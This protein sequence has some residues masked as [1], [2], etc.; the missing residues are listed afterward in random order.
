M[1]K[2]AIKLTFRMKFRH[3]YA[4]V[5]HFKPKQLA[6]IQQMNLQVIERP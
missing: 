2:T 1:N 5:V 3:F 4:R 6:V